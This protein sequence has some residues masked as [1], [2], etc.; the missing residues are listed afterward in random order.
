MRIRDVTDQPTQKCSA[1][2]VAHGICTEDFTK[3]G[4]YRVVSFFCKQLEVD[5]PTLLTQDATSHVEFMRELSLVA[6]N[7]KDYHQLLSAWRQNQKFVK[8][9]S[10]V[11]QLTDDSEQR[12][13]HLKLRLRELAQLRVTVTSLATQLRSCQE[14]LD[15]ITSLIPPLLETKFSLEKSIPCLQDSIRAQKQRKFNKLVGSTDYYL[16][17]SNSIHLSWE[18]SLDSISELETSCSNLFP[19]T[20]EQLKSFPSLKDSCHRLGL[21][22]MPSEIIGQHYDIEREDNGKLKAVIDQLVES[23][24]VLLLQ[25]QHTLVLLDF[26]EL[27]F[28][29]GLVHELLTLDL[30]PTTEECD[31]RVERA[32]PNTEG[33]FFY[34]KTGPIPLE[35][36][37]PQL[38]TTMMEFIQLHGFAAHVRRRSGTGTSCG[39]RIEDIRQH[40]L[41][42]VQGLSSVSRSK[43]YNLLKPA[44][45]NTAEAHRHKNALDVRVGVKACDVSK[46]NKNAHEYFATV[47]F[48]RQM[49]A[50]HQKECSIFS[51]DSKAKVAYRGASC[52]PLPPDE[53]FFPKQ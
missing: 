53:N 11:K 51:C 18:A 48:V 42:N 50:E 16:V 36:R 43:I 35:E 2:A 7:F 4:Q 37:Y 9:D 52:I 12:L 30:N 34:K 39:V 15:K 14:K 49:C 1:A 21:G 19:L 28:R 5:E 10:K 3:D 44:R 22:C 17:A 47:S 29:P 41:K 23:F 24:P 31:D 40:V 46:E 38:L 6:T 13:S 26:T 8:S 25:K 33:I 32:S 27:Q 45:S 20:T